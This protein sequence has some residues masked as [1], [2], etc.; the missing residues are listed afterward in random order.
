M[1]DIERRIVKMEKLGHEMALAGATRPTGIPPEYGEHIR[2]MGDMMV[3]AFQA[4]LTRICTFM[5]ANDGSN[6]SYAM[7]GVPEGHHDMSHHGSD[8]V[9]LEKKRLIDR[10]HIDQLGYVL[11]KLKSIKEADGNLLDN[12]MIVYGAG[13]SDGNAHNHD[14]LPVLFAGHAGGAFKSGRHLVYPNHTPM[15]NLFLSM[16]DRMGVR[17]ETL[18]NSTGKLAQLW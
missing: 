10:Y 1:R 17:I 5:F 16:L 14:N 12:S 18:G 15:N 9:K 4:D 3:L 6:R 13:I 2:L 8:P 7:I 11:R